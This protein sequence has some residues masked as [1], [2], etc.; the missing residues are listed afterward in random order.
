MR[1]FRRKA[2]GE[3]VDPFSIRR[4]NADTLEDIMQAVAEGTYSGFPRDGKYLM[5]RADFYDDDYEDILWRREASYRDAKKALK[6]FQKYCGTELVRTSTIHLDDIHGV[7]GAQ[8]RDRPYAALVILRPD[9]FGAAAL[10][11]DLSRQIGGHEG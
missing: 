11:R 7:W 9:S 8:P 10:H 3:Q 5:L 2:K 1:L 4:A 6:E